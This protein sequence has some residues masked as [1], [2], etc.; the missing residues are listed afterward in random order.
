M[1]LDTHPWPCFCDTFVERLGCCSTNTPD[2]YQ[3]WLLPIQECRGPWAW[4]ATKF[5]NGKSV[6]IWLVLGTTVGVNNH[7]HT[8]SRPAGYLVEETGHGHRQVVFVLHC[9]SHRHARPLPKCLISECKFLI[10]LLVLRVG[11]LAAVVRRFVSLLYRRICPI[12][13]L[14]YSPM[15]AYQAHGVG[16]MSTGSPD[17]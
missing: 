1:L 16:G 7:L 9:G 17:H 2:C 15:A 10:P 13:I 12:I 14:V 6:V 5:S 11:I 3:H 8:H 4:I